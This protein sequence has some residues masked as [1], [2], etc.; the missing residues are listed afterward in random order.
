MKWL[1]LFISKFFVFLK[2]KQSSFGDK[3]TFDFFDNSI[4]QIE[5]IRQ[6]STETL[7]VI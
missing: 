7:I 5:L 4:E 6:N 2:R 3:F 1:T